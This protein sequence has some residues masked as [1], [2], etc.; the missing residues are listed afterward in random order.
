MLQ[1]KL[2]KSL[3]LLLAAVKTVPADITFNSL[4]SE[5]DQWQGATRSAAKLGH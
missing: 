3:L 1:W 2:L 5:S 4:A